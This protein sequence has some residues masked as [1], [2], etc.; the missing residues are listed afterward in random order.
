M[1]IIG[2][3]GARG[4]AQENT[5]RAVDIAI[6][7]GV[8]MIEVDLRLK[9][10]VVVLSHDPITQSMEY[11]GLDE[12]L[13]R[14]AGKTP[15]NLEI[16]E[17]AVVEKL[18]KAIEEYSGELL[19]SSFDYKTLQACRKLL[20]SIPI[21]VLDS[22]SGVRATYRAKKLNTKRIHMNQRWLWRGF[23]SSMTQRGWQLYA[24]TVNS[25]RQA[26]V[27]EKAGLQGIFTDYPSRF[28]H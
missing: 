25:E 4:E 20:P 2:H 8:D 9:D 27:F 6:S 28:L 26:R 22:W 11:Y 24:F 1:K 21:A 10:K 19:L 23:I 13:A 5:E 16:K 17:L 14:V 3:R 15:L 12:L 18:V 7:A